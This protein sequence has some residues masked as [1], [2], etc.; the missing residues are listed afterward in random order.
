MR[1]D[2]Y[3]CRWKDL[4]LYLIQKKML[5]LLHMEIYVSYMETIQWML[6]IYFHDKLVTVEFL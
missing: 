4:V 3:P 6:L 2:H 1:Q 5:Q